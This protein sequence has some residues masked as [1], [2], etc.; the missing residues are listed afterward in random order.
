[1][2]SDIKRKPFNMTLDENLVREAKKKAI[3][4]GKPL[5]AFVEDAVRVALAERPAGKEPTDD[6]E[7]ARVKCEVTNS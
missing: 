4:L 7:R 6:E 5:Y 2:R 1:M 3:D